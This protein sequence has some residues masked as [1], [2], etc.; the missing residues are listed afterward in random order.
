VNTSCYLAQFFNAIYVLNGDSK[1]PNSIYIYDAG[2]KSWSTQSTTPGSF[3]FSSA[4]A[5]LDH[6]TNVFCE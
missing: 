5:I 6:D 2:A 1:N 3:D 4:E